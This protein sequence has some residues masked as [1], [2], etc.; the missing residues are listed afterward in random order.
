MVKDHKMTN[1]D[2]EV[3]VV[4]ASLLHDV[5]MSIDRVNHEEM[6]LFIAHQKAMELL[7][8]I[9]PTVPKRAI[10]SGVLH[11]ILNHRAEGRP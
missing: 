6:G 10:V 8:G 4:L 5:G 9:Y 7:E 1:E 11:A 3:V 2:A